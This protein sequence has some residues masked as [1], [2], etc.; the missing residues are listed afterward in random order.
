[1]TRFFATFMDQGG[2]ILYLANGYD[3]KVIYD[4]ILLGSRH[5]ADP[6]TEQFIR[7]IELLEQGRLCFSPAFPM[8]PV[9]E[10]PSIK[11]E[12]ITFGSFNSTMKYNPELFTLWQEC[13]LKY[14]NPS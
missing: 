13:F 1:M 5:F 8:P 12:F 7:P 9:E 11:N 2:Q 3:D 14:L 6:L 10:L 4:A